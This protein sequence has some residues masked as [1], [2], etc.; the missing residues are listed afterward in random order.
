MLVL[1]S[2]DRLRGEGQA[3]CAFTA[4]K[5]YNALFVLV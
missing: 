1:L 3:H 5:K 4:D 2:R